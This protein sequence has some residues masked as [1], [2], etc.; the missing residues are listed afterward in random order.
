MGD[1]SII[2]T[3]FGTS[4]ITYA[5]SGDDAQYFVLD[6]STIKL[7]SD[8]SANY[9]VQSRYTLTV[10]ATNSAGETITE[11]VVVKIENVNEGVN[12]VTAL[13][14][15]S[16]DEDADFSFTV[17][18]TTFIDIDGDALTYS[19]TL[20]DGDALPTWL[21][22]NAITRTFT[23]TPLN[24][25]VGV[26][27]VTVTASDGSFSASNT[28]SL[29]VV[30]T[31]DEPTAVVLSSTAIDENASGVIIGNISTI[32]DDN[33]HGDT[34][35]YTLSGSDADSFELIGEQLKF[36]DTISAN[37]EVKN[38]YSLVLT[39]TDNDNTSVQQS[40][41][42]IINDINEA[43]TNITLSAAAVD[44]NVEGIV[45]GTLVTTDEDVGDTVSYS[46]S[47][48]DAE[49]F[50][51]IDGQLKL[52]SGV[53]AD[54]ETK[55]TYTIK[56]MATDS[57]GLF[58]SK[59]LSV[60]INNINEAPVAIELSSNNVQSDLSAGNIGLI[61]VIDEDFDE[62][63]TYS[64]NDDRFEVVD[65]TLKLKE[66]QSINYDSESSV[67]IQITVTDSGGAEYSDTFLI[68]VYDF[69]IKGRFYAQSEVLPVGS[70]HDIND[71]HAVVGWNNNDYLLIAGTSGGS[72]S[73][74]ATAG[75][76]YLV[77]GYKLPLIFNRGSENLPQPDLEIIK[78]AKVPE[79]GTGCSYTT[80]SSGNTKTFIW[81]DF[82]Q[83]VK[84]DN[85]YG[86]NED[87]LAFESNEVDNCNESKYDYRVQI[88]IMKLSL[89]FGD[90]EISI[91]GDDFTQYEDVDTVI[92]TSNKYGISMRSGDFNG[93]GRGDIWAYNKDK[94][95]LSSDRKAEKDLNKINDRIVF[96]NGNGS[97][98]GDTIR[99]VIG[100]N[101]DAHDDLFFP[102]VSSGSYETVTC[103][104]TGLWGAPTF[105]NGVTSGVTVLG[106][107]VKS[108]SNWSS[109]ENIKVSDG[110]FFNTDPYFI[111]DGNEC[112]FFDKQP[113]NK[114]TGAWMAVKGIGARDDYKYSHNPHYKDYFSN[115]DPDGD[116]VKN[117]VLVVSTTASFDKDE[118]YE[119][120]P[121]YY[122]SPVILILQTPPLDDA[123]NLYDIQNKSEDFYQIIFPDD[124]E[125]KAAK[126]LGD[127]DG[128]GK[129]E[130]YVNFCSDANGVAT[131]N[132]QVCRS[133][134]I[135]GSDDKENLIIDLNTENNRYFLSEELPSIVGE[136]DVSS[137]RKGNAVDLYDFDGDGKKDLLM[138]GYFLS[139]FD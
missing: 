19:A 93:D 116:G 91:H 47:G 87:G 56:L 9:E 74:N 24:N 125:I 69:M 42:I 38:T 119:N 78:A 37:Y 104:Y 66:N 57:S 82:D 52:K 131:S 1:L 138:G 107:I 49:S 120:P 14:N 4:D 68:Y 33:I 17:P 86:N 22:F 101:G 46:L 99:N 98:S 102:S 112:S 89:L 16:N 59:Q 85:Y 110:D 28:F 73:S 32:D 60:I 71:N 10:T 61:V 136:Y 123:V 72:I 124:H 67:T 35:T 122:R 129:D 83:M 137:G 55:N 100:K 103:F 2:D 25:N 5:L 18:N 97:D 63:F 26:I 21:S 70:L 127:M 62:T 133:T 3:A 76:G 39:A 81:R 139:I 30:N 34:H 88:F 113:G 106:R 111:S 23:G 29:T 118:N 115:Y 53:S 121:W 109:G 95:L 80:D 58:F 40:L 65:G 6:G 134:V 75:E 50:E 132:Y 130:L 31:N 13:S 8:V 43:P 117:G 15:Q 44:E 77:T 105:L 7:K 126:S 84:I 64:I 54:Y 51:I 27:N 92:D 114:P 36:I 79:T 128:D 41:I 20:S 45:V 48:V 12:L 90:S 96:T 94:I 11:K 135:F 108:D